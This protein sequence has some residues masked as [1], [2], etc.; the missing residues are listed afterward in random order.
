MSGTNMRPV[1]RRWL[2]RVSIALVL[3][4]S[5]VFLTGYIWLRQSLPQLDGNIETAGVSLPVSVLRDA[6]GVPTI[7]AAN[8]NDASYALGY[9]HAQERFFQMDLL[10]RSGA[11]ELSEILGDATLKF[12]RQRRRHRFRHLS[13]EAEGIFSKEELAI[14][15]AYTK[16]VNDGLAALGAAP[17][18]YALLGAEPEEWTISV[19]DPMRTGHGSPGIYGYAPVDIFYDNVSVMENQ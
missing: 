1:I 14:A 7:Q 9:L 6:D 11:G 12:D 4:V 8:R 2:G 3:L 5:L 13:E 16:G 17:F 18:E 19:K 10:R 15:S